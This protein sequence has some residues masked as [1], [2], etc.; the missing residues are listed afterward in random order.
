[1][2][3][4]TL[5]SVEDYDDLEVRYPLPFREQFE[6]HSET[7]E[8]P[9]SWA[10]GVARSESLFMTDI[11]SIAGAVGVMQ[12]MPE[13][14][15]RT[16]SEIKLP[17][18][19][20]TTLTDPDSNIQLGT[21][22]LGKMLRRFGHNPILATAAYNAGPLR[23]EKWLPEAD[24]LDARIW[25]ESIPFNETRGYVRRVLFTDTIFHWRLTGETRRLSESLAAI[26]PSPPQQ[27]A[28]AERERID[29]S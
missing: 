20:V 6:K 12:L 22:Y 24:R 14:G 21:F 28:N 5:A 7:A 10:Y 27:L 19:G 9:Y 11:R 8:I 29:G 16:A 23:V 3:I 1:M 18:G 2:S 15:R 17:Y 4:A 13:T 26:D 25:I